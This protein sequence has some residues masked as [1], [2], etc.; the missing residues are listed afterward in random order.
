[1]TVSRKYIPGRIDL[2][3]FTTWFISEVQEIDYYSVGSQEMWPVY[4]ASGGLASAMLKYLIWAGNV[5]CE[6]P[7]RNA[8]LYN[9]A[10]VTG[11]SF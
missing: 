7:K 1:M 8:V 10:P 9:L 11:F 6:N 5:G 2:I 4:G 3:D